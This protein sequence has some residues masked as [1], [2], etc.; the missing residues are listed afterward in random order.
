VLPTGGAV[1]GTLREVYN[2]LGKLSKL[3]TRQ[4]RIWNKGAKK[5]RGKT[6]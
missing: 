5:V 1:A 4:G 2:K 3:K 6:S